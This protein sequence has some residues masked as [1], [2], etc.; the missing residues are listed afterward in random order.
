MELVK[1]K[2][3][4][5][6]NRTT[7]KYFVDFCKENVIGDSNTRYWLIMKNLL[8][9]EKVIQAIL[10]KTTKV[11]IKLGKKDEIDHEYN[12]NEKLQNF[13]GF[14]RYMCRF[15][16]KDDLNKYKHENGM[17]SDNG[18][19]E[20]NGLDKT[21]AIIMPYYSLSSIQRYEWN[22]SNFSI[23]KELLKDVVKI[24]IFTNKSIG[25]LHNDIHLDNIMLK[26]RKNGDVKVDIIDFG[27]ST[28][29]DEDKLNYKKLGENFTDL[30]S[31]VIRLKFM[32]NYTNL[33]NYARKMRDPFENTDL[34][35][36]DIYDCIDELRY[37]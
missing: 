37:I 3:T 33:I 26:K 27:K 31:S 6:I 22:D 29:K 36:N 18:F 19:C 28:I 7:K 12:I 13:K 17:W 20:P 5:S 24:L 25:F 30:F 21:N 34:N 11:V 14:V 23:F 9:D 16:C 8:L 32:G 1:D 2:Y 15:S 4:R 35:L 10:F